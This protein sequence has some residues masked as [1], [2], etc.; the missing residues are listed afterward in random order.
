MSQIV[1]RPRHLHTKHTMVWF[2][3]KLGRRRGLLVWYLTVV[4][5]L[6]LG[7]GFLKNNQKSPLLWGDTEQMTC[8][9][10]ADTTTAFCHPGITFICK[11]F[12]TI[13][14]FWGSLYDSCW[15]WDSSRQLLPLVT[16][17]SLTGLHECPPTT[18]AIKDLLQKFRMRLSSWIQMSSLRGRECGKDSLWWIWMIRCAE[19]STWKEFLPYLI[20]SPVTHCH[21]HHLHKFSTFI[22]SREVTADPGK[23]LRQFPCLQKL[24]DSGLVTPWTRYKALPMTPSTSVGA[25]WDFTAKIRPKCLTAHR[26]CSPLHILPGSQPWANFSLLHSLRLKSVAGKILVLRKAFGWV[27]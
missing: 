13:F 18:T 21:Q 15:N 16:A 22:P 20:I 24:E 23:R 10:A 27:L 14:P 25:T 4:F 3:S 8:E 17:K 19:E 5:T 2:C 9:Q 26:H 6:F 12:C 11:L 7:V 1:P